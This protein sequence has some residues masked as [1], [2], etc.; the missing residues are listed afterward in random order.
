MYPTD[1]TCFFTQKDLNLQLDVK[2]KIR[3]EKHDFSHY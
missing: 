2:I 3:K 1:I